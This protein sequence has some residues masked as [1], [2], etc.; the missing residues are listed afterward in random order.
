MPKAVFALNYPFKVLLVL[1]ACRSN[2]TRLRQSPGKGWEIREG[3]TG[4][5][6]EGIVQ[7]LTI[8]CNIVALNESNCVALFGQ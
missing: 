5:S 8:D 3:R 1:L 6:E 4:E 7:K 2:K